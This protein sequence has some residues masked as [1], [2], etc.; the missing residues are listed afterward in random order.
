M[1]IYL[2]LITSL[3][4]SWRTSQ[5]QKVHPTNIPNKLKNFQVY[6]ERNLNNNWG[7][8]NFSDQ[9][10]NLKKPRFVHYSEFV[11]LI[12]IKT[13]SGHSKQRKIIQLILEEAYKWC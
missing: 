13:S 5:N 10:L 4:S 6:P 12:E 9:V 3:L 1:Y 7:H 2:D 8:F 11:K